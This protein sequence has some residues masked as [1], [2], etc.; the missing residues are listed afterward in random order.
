MMLMASDYHHDRKRIQRFVL[1]LRRTV[2]GWV[3]FKGQSN[4]LSSG[5]DQESYQIQLLV[6]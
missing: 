3:K 2:A 5:A 4:L 6:P 1:Y